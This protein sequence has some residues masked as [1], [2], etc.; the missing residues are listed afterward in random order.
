M[1][2]LKKI[3]LRSKQLWIILKY[4]T[5]KLFSV[6]T[7]TKKYKDVWLI[8]ERGDEARDNG[9]AFYKY[10]EENHP[11]KNFYY[12]IKKNSPDIYKIDPSRIIF[13]QSSKNFFLDDF[14]PYI[15][16]RHIHCP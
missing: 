11:E 9:Y 6:F 16:R 5:I 7:S 4:L 1:K 15:Y 12:I 2:V 10:M 3:K 14:L 8:A 13:Y